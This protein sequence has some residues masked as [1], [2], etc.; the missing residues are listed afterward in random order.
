MA[1]ETG[2]T[3]LVS[4]HQ[5]SVISGLRRNGKDVTTSFPAD[6]CRAAFADVEPRARNLPRGR[7]TA[8]GSGTAAVRG[9]AAAAPG[10]AEPRA[11]LGTAA[12]GPNAASAPG[13]IPPADSGEL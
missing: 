13:G 5:K 11:L 6:R 9:R 10:R 12:A 8:A 7:R 4:H 2:R 3:A 1:K